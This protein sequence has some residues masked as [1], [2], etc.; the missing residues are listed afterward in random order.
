MKT[1]PALQRLLCGAVLTL[2]GLACA[3]APAPAPASTSASTALWQQIQ[4]ETANNSCDGPQQC[5]SI[6]VGSKACGGPERY[7]AWSS[8]QGDGARLKQLVARHAAARREEDLRDGM[9]STCS[10]VS[11][12]GATCEA[13]R[14]VLR[15]PGPG[16]SPQQ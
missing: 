15:A 10:V 2:S 9:M 6:G 12:P 13:G 4:A 1:S 16:G 8:K 14:C 7:L 11:D 3:T 5:Q